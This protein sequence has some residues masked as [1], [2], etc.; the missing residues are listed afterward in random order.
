VA[1]S[2]GARLGAYEI[3]AQ[4]GKGGMGEVYRARDTRLGRDVAI[5]ILPRELAADPDRLGRLTREAR[6]LASLNHPNIGAIY[7][8]EHGIAEGPLG[9]HSSDEV[10]ALILELVDGE[11]L[12]DRLAFGPLPQREAVDTARQIADALAA[13]H[14]KG[15]VHRDLKP[16]NIKITPARMVKVLDFGLATA[17]VE[18]NLDGV[19]QLPTVSND[20]TGAGVILGTA[21]YM[22]PEQAR[23]Q[24]IDKR[25]D[26]WAFGCVL[27]EMLTG[28]RAFAGATVSD[29]IVAVLEHEPSWER[30]PG[31][32][33][34]PIRRLLRRCLQ[35]DREERLRDIADA[36]I[37]LDELVRGISDG[38]SPST[39]HAGRSSVITWGVVAA[40]IVIVSAASGWAVRTWSETTIDAVPAATLTRLT[41]DSAFASMPA[42]SR[43]GRLLAYSSDRAGRADRDLWIQQT[44]GGVPLRLTDDPA[45]DTQPDFSP[46]GREI[47]FRSER[48]GGGIFVVSTLGGPARLIVAGGRQP[49][50]SPDASRIAYTFGQVR[51][52]PSSSQSSLNILPLAGG[53]PTRLLPDFESVSGPVWSPDGRALLAFARHDRASPLSESLDWWW[54]PI[55]GREPVR[56]GVLDLPGLRA[57]EVV[58]RAWTADGV[59]FSDGQ[60]LRSVAV[61]QTTGRVNGPARLITVASGAYEE[62][63]TS[64]DGS[65]VFAALTKERVIAR[66]VLNDVNAPMLP[67]RLH[68]DGQDGA[69]RASITRDGVMIAF[70]QQIQEQWEIWI[71]MLPTG[72]QRLLIR[73]DAPTS[74][75]PTLSSDGARV[76]YTIGDTTGMGRG[77][78]LSTAGGTPQQV[79]Q[80]CVL[81][82]FI[83]DNRRVLAQADGVRALRLYDV[84]GSY[85]DLVTSPEGVLARPH[86]SAGDKWLAFRRTLNAVSRIFVV[87]F[88]PGHPP[89]DNLW[90]PI[91]EPTT[92]GRPAGWSLDGSVLYLLLDA[93][94]FRCLWGQRVDQTSGRPLGGPF[95]VR[96][97]HGSRVAT[98]GGVSSTLGNAVSAVGFIYEAMDTRSDIWK[99]TRTAARN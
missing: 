71:K 8:L 66:A 85:E 46:D 38:S 96:H 79:C 42:L 36:R 41:Y 75:N 22:S 47:A 54:I 84:N 11:T 13:A 61:S 3:T 15:I 14:D 97:F 53:E 87:P 4:I 93:D 7:G 49:R 21:P 55:D 12:A 76:A 78:V 88:S 29:T 91:D 59:L 9:A 69:Y 82:G 57:A 32:T 2:A 10:R 81:Y 73:V 70:E 67:V 20:R 39:S 95:P 86:V 62:P 98:A 45:D 28:T 51:G 23:G 43:D 17:S 60:N 99:L 74:V 65:I 72:E 92:T 27:F 58:P 31:S 34:P 1:L 50:F 26:V 30:L 63:A 40:A 25:T 80:Q 5:K 64:N 18:P 90:I 16:A 35:K 94:G 68:A 33:P 83:S 37:E 89:P 52:N 24:A 19:T 6:I 56:T 77:Y 44:E 48:D